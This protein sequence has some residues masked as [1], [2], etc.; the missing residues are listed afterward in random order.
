MMAFR[1]LALAAAALSLA[2]CGENGG[3]KT[4]GLCLPFPSDTA[5]APTEPSA[6]VDDCAHRWAYSLASSSD[7]ADVV[8]DAVLAACSPQISKWNQGGLNAGQGAEAAEAPSLLTG[9]SISPFAA[10]YRFAQSRAMFYVVQARAGKCSAPP[11]EK[12]APKGLTA[13]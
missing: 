11:T 10:N 3:G 12:G 13:R 9:D 7:T 6:I 8:A 4:A 5:A 1:T 2:A